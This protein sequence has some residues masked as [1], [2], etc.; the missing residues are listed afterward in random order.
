MKIFVDSLGCPKAF[1]DVERMCYFLLKDD[2]LLVSS[3]EEADL[4]IV[5]T[6]GFTEAAKKENIQAILYYADLK[7][8]KPSLKLVVTGCLSERYKEKLL[9]LIPEIDSA[10]G[11]KDQSI[12]GKVIRDQQK[13]FLDC[14]QF[15]DTAYTDERTLTFS[16]LNYAYL[17]ISEGCNRS[18]SFCVIPS[19]RGKQRSRRI[20][21]ILKEAEKLREEGISELIIISEDTLSYGIDLYGERK[22]IKLLER[23]GEFD[24]PWI[25]LMY[26]F[27]ED[28]IYE[29]VDFLSENER[30]CNY[31]DLPFQHVS[32]KIL[33][34][35]KRKGDFEYYL[36]MLEKIRKINP[37]ISV[38][39]A[40]IVG[41]PGETEEDFKLL[42]EFLEI[43][44]LNRV[45]FFEYS[46]E[47]GAF[48]YNLRPKVSKKI[49][50][51]RIREL[52]KLQTYIS[53][54]LL[55]R[56]VGKKIKCI[57][58]GE[59]LLNRKY[60]LFRTE[61]DAPE[62]DGVVKVLSCD[63]EIFE[64]SFATVKIL[65]AQTHDLVGKIVEI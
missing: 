43:A 37:V 14:Q 58:D 42:K 54:E 10:I 48:S 13:G 3:P 45:G 7:K 1:V 22:I 60:L 41:Y 63:D 17:K 61:F 35:M 47:E 4:V 36:E 59:I 38:R 55:E 56:F 5:N 15:N 53:K 65:R 40:F 49:A 51:K 50:R 33:G 62:I 8:K 19:I 25:R 29:V 9:E 16:G 6:C 20:E 28:Y 32:K 27:P 64:S 2:H 24:F 26:L 21:D 18:C 39:S 57:F 30:F 12:V 52:Q 31:I 44:K 23:L 46:D 34:S 11:V